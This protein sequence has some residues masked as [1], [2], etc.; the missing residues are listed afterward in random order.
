MLNQSMVMAIAKKLDD[1]NEENFNI[2]KRRLSEATRQCNA[3]TRQNHS[4]QKDIR[5]I[6]KRLQKSENLPLADLK[7]K[8]KLQKFVTK[9]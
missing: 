9:F 5:E 6:K 4:L 3:V 8:K 2:L 1:E 7:C